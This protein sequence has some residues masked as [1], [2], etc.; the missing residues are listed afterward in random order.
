MQN[1]EL[2]EVMKNISLFSVLSNGEIEKLTENAQIF[3]FSSG[4]NITVGRDVV[5]VIMSGSVSVMKNELLMRI[6]SQGSVSGVA[7]L[8]G[9]EGEP[10]SSLRANTQSRVAL[11]SGEN[12]RTLIR[13]SAGFA[14]AYIRFLTSRIRFLNSRIQAYTS[15]SAEAK[16]AFHILYSDESGAGTIELG[17]SMSALADMLNI[18]RA[19]LYRA[20]DALVAKGAIER[21]GSTINILSSERLLKSLHK[22][23]KLD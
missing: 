22:E 23:N 12:M 5:T 9:N 10:V 16:L 1:S 3:D 20:F 21:K 19:S 2:F 6:M 18:G 7:S 11:I 4:E 17:A 8:Y 15:G 13:Q 14:E